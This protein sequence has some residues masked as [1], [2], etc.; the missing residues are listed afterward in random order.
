VNLLTN[1]LNCTPFRA[2]LTSIDPCFYEG[3]G[4]EP[5]SGAIAAMEVGGVFFNV[6]ARREKIE[7]EATVRLRIIRKAL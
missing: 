6:S 5:P 1:Y 4:C 2:F 7:Y 3:M